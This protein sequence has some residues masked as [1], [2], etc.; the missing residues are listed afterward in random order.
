METLHQKVGRTET[1]VFALAV[2]AIGLLTT[3]CKKEPPYILTGGYV[4]GKSMDSKGGAVLHLGPSYTCN[5]RAVPL[6]VRIESSD[7]G[8]LYHCIPVGAFV[9]VQADA[10]G[11]SAT[12]DSRGH[13]A[14]LYAQHTRLPLIVDKTDCSL[15]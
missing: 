7:S 1:F 9:K 2:T 13:S 15:N 5:G 4:T 8:T 3:G 6:D 11:P 12:C 14:Y 10:I